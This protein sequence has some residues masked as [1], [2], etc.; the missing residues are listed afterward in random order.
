MSMIYK[1]VIPLHISSFIF[2]LEGVKGIGLHLIV[3]LFV[4]K[5]ER[6]LTLKI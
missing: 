5:R 1:F 2:I 4:R 3:K 6:F